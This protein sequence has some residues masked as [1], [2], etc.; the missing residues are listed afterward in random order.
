ME[1][2]K[3]PRRFLTSRLPAVA[4]QPAAATAR[5]KG[6]HRV[7]HY[8]NRRRFLRQ[9]AASGAAVVSLPTLIQTARGQG[10]SPSDRLNLGIIGVGGRGGDNLKAVAGE[11]IAALCDVD[12]IRL[13][14]AGGQFPKAKKY[15]DFRAMLNEQK[16]LDA[17]VVSTP[18]HCHAPA[19][20]MAMNRGLHVYC[21]KPLTHS[22]GEARVMS[23]TA[24]RKKLVTQ[25]GTGAQS[26]EDEIRSVE[27]IRSGALG[28]IREAH[29]WTN[30]PIWP[31]GQNRPSG[32]DPVPPHLDWDLWIGPAPMR[33]YKSVYADG[34]F[35]GRE[36]YHPFVWRGWWDFGT[37]ALGDIAPH[38]MNVVFWALELGAP[39]RVEAES[40]GM[41][42]E[43]FPSWSIIHFDF[44]AGKHHDPLRMTWYDG[45]KK[46]S[47]EVAEGVALKDNGKLFVGQQGKLL[48]Q[49]EKP[50]LL[51][52]AKFADYK[53]PEP[54]LPRRIEIHKDWI[55]AIKA[56]DQTGCHFGYSGPMT[57]GYLLGN[58]ALR[59]G[60][61]IEWDAT[62]MKV[63]NC[64][65]AQQYV[66]RDYRQG[67]SLEM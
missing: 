53:P 32:E 28:R 23:E 55:R 40:S 39:T 35:Q 25:M 2:E 33:P 66:R 58:I 13:D 61:A 48:L 15:T 50:I 65:E 19:S 57:E 4:T 16:G 22:I 5:T 41:M 46:P 10:R 62:G 24:A 3:T 54:T 67:W 49:D 34:P 36:V 52:T 43:A 11:N 17:V 37:G 8:L 20:V 29:V 31:Q 47:A 9:A 59:V 64:R 26:E 45:G 1:T 12:R 7:A 21:E 18:D 14:A 44:P 27:I 60:R 63:T 6:T 42:P 51:P 38:S 30:R 56:G